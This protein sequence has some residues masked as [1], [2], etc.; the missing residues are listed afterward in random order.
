MMR[1]TYFAVLSLLSM[2]TLLYVH[3]ENPP[4]LES[5][6]Q[7]LERSPFLHTINLENH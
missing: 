1:R 7:P 4:Y 2:L 5:I 3:V 6:L